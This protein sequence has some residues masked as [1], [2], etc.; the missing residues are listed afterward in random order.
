[1]EI[2]LFQYLQ[3]SQHLSLDY[4]KAYL[5]Q[6]IKQ[7]E[8]TLTGLTKRECWGSWTFL[9]KKSKKKKLHFLPG[10]GEQHFP[11]ASPLY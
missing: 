7:L 4:P 9:L 6:Q 10:L 8:R 3:P 1:M 5:K 2:Q 11:Q